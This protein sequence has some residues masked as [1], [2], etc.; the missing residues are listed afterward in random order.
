MGKLHAVITIRFMGPM[1]GAGVERENM[2]TGTKSTSQTI[3]PIMAPDCFQ[4]ILLQKER[5]LQ[6]K[7]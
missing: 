1:Q 2:E 3:I 7:Y 6:L 4:I 5:A